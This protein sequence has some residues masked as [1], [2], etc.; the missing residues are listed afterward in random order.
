MS[1]TLMPWTPSVVALDTEIEVLAAQWV[2]PYAQAHH[3]SRTRDWLVHLDGEATLE[4][5]LSAMTHDIERMFPGGPSIDFATIE[6]DSPFYLYPHS[7][8]SAEVVGIWLAGAGPTASKVDIDEV[9]RLVA[10][11]EVGGLLGADL[12]QAAD[13]LSFLETL[14]GVAREWV[15]SG[16]CTRDKAAAKLAYS[17]D[18]IRIP[19]AQSPALE[20][21]GWAMEQ[22]PTSASTGGA[23]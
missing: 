2:S 16:V 15:V 19:A 21:Y 1:A 14:A 6:W 17:V 10:L 18:R 5:R 11:H 20:L 12:I 9:R 3:L 4:M 7:I 22:L 13:S 23:A 8:R